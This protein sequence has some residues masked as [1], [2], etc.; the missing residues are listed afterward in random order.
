MNRKYEMNEN[1]KTYVKKK[2]TVTKYITVDYKK[3]SRKWWKWIV[4]EDN[5]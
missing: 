5:F 3:K 2:N 4:I 1:S